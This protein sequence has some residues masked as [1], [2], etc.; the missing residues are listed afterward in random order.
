[1]ARHRPAGANSHK[2][3]EP[4]PGVE[5][6]EMGR[7]RPAGATSYKIG[8]SLPGVEKT[9]VRRHRPAGRGQPLTRTRAGSY[10]LTPETEVEESR[11]L[12]GLGQPP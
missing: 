6:T 3:G 12:D 7:H 11:S 4:L 10:F 8:K 1:M 9:E 2:I 5:K